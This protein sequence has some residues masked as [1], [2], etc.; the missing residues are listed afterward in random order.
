MGVFFQALF[1]GVIRMGEVD[2]P[3]P[4][5]PLEFSDH[6]F[7]AIIGKWSRSYPDKVSAAS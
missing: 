5:A 4:G 1:P 7:F 2:P 3:H 6:K